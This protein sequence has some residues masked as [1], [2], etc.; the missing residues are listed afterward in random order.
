M[1]TRFLLLAVTLFLPF[2]KIYSEN[3]ILKT[4]ISKAIKSINT[5]TSYAFADLGLSE[6]ELQLAENIK[7]DTTFRTEL[8][9]N[10]PQIKD[11]AADFLRKIGN[12]D[13]ALIDRISDIISRVSQ[14]VIFESGNE[15]G[16]ISLRSSLPTPKFDKPR[17]HTD[18]NFFTPSGL[19]IRFTTTLQGSPTLVY[20]LPKSLRKKFYEN[21]RNRDY[22]NNLLDFSK[23]LSNKRGEGT[24]FIIS[25]RNNS[26]VH[27]EP[28]IDKKRLFFSV[29]PGS[30]KQITEAYERMVAQNFVY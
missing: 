4:N 25:D 26:T 18:G 13:E 1:F 16:W 17:W 11:E 3:Q 28:K 2:E 23:A 14:A 6:E 21:S 27:S 30:E 22:L 29:I 24:I 20:P 8:F 10:L 9:G 15:S 19:T 7:I 5:K 12:D